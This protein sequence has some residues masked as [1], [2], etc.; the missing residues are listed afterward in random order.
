MKAKFPNLTN[1]RI[2]IFMSESMVYVDD[3]DDNDNGFAM[4]LFGYFLIGNY[5]GAFLGN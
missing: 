4:D 5:L 1:F 2:R 3:D